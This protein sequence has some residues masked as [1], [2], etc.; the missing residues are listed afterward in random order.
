MKE[1]NFQPAVEILDAWWDDLMS[2]TPPVQYRVGIGE[3]QRIDVGPGRVTLVGGSPGI[4][5]TALI[6]QMVFDALAISTTLKAMVCNVEMHPAAILERQLARFSGIDLTT[7]RNR[8][9][10]LEHGDALARG[11]DALDA[12]IDRLAFVRPPYDL[13]NVA[14]SAEAHDARLIVLDYIQRIEAGGKHD[15]DRQAVGETMS[16]IRRFTDECGAAVIA[17]AALSRSRD[18]RGRAS[19]TDGLSLASFRG[20][21]ELE[22]GADDAFILVPDGDP[23]EFSSAV[24]VR[25]SHLKSRNGE[26][27]DLHLLFD[28]PRQHFVDRPIAP[29][30]HESATPDAAMFAMLK[31][32]IAA[33]DATF[34]EDDL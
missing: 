16:T 2:G 22:F 20:T 8:Q 28:R 14:H 15:D 11:K 4:G 26:T 23:E 3:L 34:G 33:D 30:D 5:K 1:A 24:P 13:N 29:V 19:Y 18:S 27:R 6:S 12:V 31:A 32:N 10:D 7:I 25:L 17:V 9:L 21:S